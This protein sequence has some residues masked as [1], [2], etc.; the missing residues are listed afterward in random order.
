[1]KPTLSALVGK[2]IHFIGIGG[3]GMSGLARIALTHQITVTGSDSKDSSVISALVALGAKITTSHA[4]ENV[5]GA[6]LV[7]YSSAISNN[8][9][10]RIRAE[11]LHLQ[12]LI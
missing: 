10:E 3:A 11:E 12:M 9:V 4:S 7:V 8:N 2:R 1:M 5:D 6:D